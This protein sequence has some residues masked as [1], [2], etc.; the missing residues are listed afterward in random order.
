MRTETTHMAYAA[1]E[2]VVKAHVGTEATH[3]AHPAC[4]AGEKA[5]M[6]TLLADKAV[7]SDFPRGD[8]KGTFQ[9]DSPAKLYFRPRGTRSLE[10][11]YANLP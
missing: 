11:G 10:R 3:M 8:T 9:F 4:E 5:H 2:A 1:C 6:E 7:V